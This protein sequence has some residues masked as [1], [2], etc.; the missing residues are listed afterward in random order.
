MALLIFILNVLFYFILQKKYLNLALIL[1]LILSL[2]FSI[3]SFVP[4]TKN[5]FLNFIGDT[6]IFMNFSH[7]YSASAIRNQNYLDNPEIY[8]KG[9]EVE[10]FPSTLNVTKK[11]LDDRSRNINQ[12]EIIYFFD[13]FHGSIFLNA[14]IM[15]KNDYLLG[16]GIKNFRK[17][18]EIK[19]LT[20]NDVEYI[21]QCST[22]PHNVYIE[23]LVETG[24]I[25]FGLILSF[26][27]IFLF[28]IIKN[29]NYKSNLDCSLFSLFLILL[30]PFQSTGSFF[31]SRYIFFYFITLIFIN[32]FIIRNKQ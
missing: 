27:V 13:N 25:G 30:F 23:I 16:I 32:F 10:K 11:R 20:L 6:G 7:K 15:I 31:S 17:I 19:V 12:E 4:K 26:L 2:V 28:K 24:L 1:V 9:R 14:I 3:Y 21:L 8:I 22:H 29:F 18:C 5:H